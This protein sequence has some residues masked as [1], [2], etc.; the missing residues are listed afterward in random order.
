M[1]R[2]S[3]ITF[4][5][6]GLA[7]HPHLSVYQQL[8]QEFK[9]YGQFL[10]SDTDT[11]WLSCYAQDS[12]SL[13]CLLPLLV[14]QP[15]TTQII[16]SFIQACFDKQVPLAVRC[17][18]TGLT[19]GCVT[20]QKGVVLLTGHLRAVISYDPT[21][22]QVVVEPGV[23]PEQLNRIGL[24]DGWIFPLE[25][26]TQGCAGLAGCVSTQARGYHQSKNSWID[27]LLSVTLTNGQ[28]TT[29]QVPP[30][31]AIGAEGL[32]GV[33]LQIKIQLQK[34]PPDKKVVQTTLSFQDV[35]SVK[36]QLGRHSALQAI[37]WQEKNTSI[38]IL[39]GDT[40]RV[41]DAWQK[42]KS[43]DGSCQL[44]PSM[45]SIFPTNFHSQ[46]L[47]L[48]HALPICKIKSVVEVFIEFI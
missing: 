1:G 7:N 20:S 48:S 5:G 44:L 11:A 17:G 16:P 37:L 28:G 30:E 31:L 32:L 2:H 21:T 18:G 8:V 14:F 42:L 10:S 38:W 40:W 3:S 6:K 35:L 33:I 19:G 43:L 22:G 26:R 4:L 46:C 41:Q 34:N 12:Q 39:Q 45:G 23:T 25:M 24:T 29:V 15:K 27:C 36:N 13:H 47:I 9:A